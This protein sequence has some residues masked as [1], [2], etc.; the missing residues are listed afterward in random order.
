MAYSWGSLDSVTY[1]GFFS[2]LGSLATGPSA[3]SF[4]IRSLAM[5]EGSG[6]WEAINFYRSETLDMYAPNSS[7]NT[8][9]V[10]KP[11]NPGYLL[12]SFPPKTKVT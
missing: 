8:T 4:D 12:A 5:T 7:W 6:P 2:S 10:N 11:L 1:I 9:L 3:K